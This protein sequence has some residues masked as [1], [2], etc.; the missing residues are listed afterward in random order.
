MAILIKH[1]ARKI[2]KVTVKELSYSVQFTPAGNN[3]LVDRFEIIN[4]N[5]TNC[6]AH[7]K[8][9]CPEEMIAIYEYMKKIV[10]RT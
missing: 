1:D 6:E 9:L 10:E 8:A 3:K 2:E 5:F 7:T 4:D